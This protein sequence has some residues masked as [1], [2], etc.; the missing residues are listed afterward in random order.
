VVLPE[1]NTSLT[2]NNS[3]ARKG[4]CAGAIQLKVVAFLR[5]TLGEAVH[6]RIVIGK[7]FVFEGMDVLRSRVS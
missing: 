2:C 6:S 1:L 3:V 5:R 4:H 7:R